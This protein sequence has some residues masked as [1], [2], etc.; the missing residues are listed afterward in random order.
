VYQGENAVPEGFFVP[1]KG[2]VV[3]IASAP[4]LLH[5]NQDIYS[6]N[7]TLLPPGNYTAA[8]TCTGEDIPGSRSIDFTPTQDAVITVGHNA[9]LSF[10]P[11]SL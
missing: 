6:F 5:T 3:P 4:L 1:V 9:S 2:G 10:T 11:S 7:A 8:V